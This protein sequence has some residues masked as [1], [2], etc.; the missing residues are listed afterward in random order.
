MTNGAAAG[1]AAAA[2][3]IA[4]AINASGAI[5][6]VEPKDFKIILSKSDDPLVVMAT[7]GVFTFI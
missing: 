1:A 2:A 7:G 5:V 3:A 4:Q 6:S